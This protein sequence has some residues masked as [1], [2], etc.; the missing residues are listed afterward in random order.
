MLH[1]SG[2]PNYN[3]IQ[4]VS[5]M[6]YT[7]YE[8]PEFSQ[9]FRTFCISYLTGRKNE[10]FAITE[11]KSVSNVLMSE[12]I[13][14]KIVHIRSTLIITIIIFRLVN[15][16]LPVTLS[17]I[18]IRIFRVELLWLNPILQIGSI[19]LRLTF[20]LMTSDYECV[21]VLQYI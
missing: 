20:N 16:S 19:S 17:H 12:D 6:L 21:L 14:H 18:I 10:I 2:K 1:A 8:W 4:L 7:I 3:L 9:R 11:N 13:S 15:I 5:Y